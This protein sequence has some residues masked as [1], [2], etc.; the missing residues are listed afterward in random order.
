MSGLRVKV[1]LAKMDKP[2]SDRRQGWQMMLVATADSDA[3]CGWTTTTTSQLCAPT[4]ACTISLTNFHYNTVTS[5]ADPHTGAKFP[6]TSTP[7]Q[8][9]EASCQCCKLAKSSKVAACAEVKGTRGIR[10][11]P[12]DISP[13]HTHQVFT[14]AQEQSKTSTP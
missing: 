10:S 14:T 4:T 2:S 1:D 9:F 6:H 7:G 5:L 11:A 13:A 12:V 8:H 3:L